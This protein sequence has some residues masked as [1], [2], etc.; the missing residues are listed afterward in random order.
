VTLSAPP[1]FTV[2]LT[3]TDVSCFGLDNGIAAVDVVTGGVFPISYEWSN[4]QVNSQINNLSSGIYDL[5]ITDDNLCEVIASIEI[6]EP[7]EILVN[8]ST[9]DADCSGNTGSASAIA[10]GGV[11]VLSYS[12][13]C[14]SAT[15]P[16]VSGIAPGSH[17]LTVTDSNSCESVES[18]DISLSG[19]ISVV[20]DI[21]QPILCYGESNGILD[22]TTSS[23][24]TPFQ[25]QWSTGSNAFS[26]SGLGAGSYTLTLTDS[27]GCAGTSTTNIIEPE[28]IALNANIT[29][30]G[31]NGDS[32]GA[33]HLSVSG[34]TSPYSY[35]WQDGSDLP[36]IENLTAGDYSITIT[37]FNSCVI[38]EIFK[39]TQSDYSFDVNAQVVHIVC[40]GDHNGEIHLSSI[41]GI[42]PIVYNVSGLTYNSTGADHT[43]LNSGTY[44]VGATDSN[45]CSDYA[46]VILS[47]PAQLAANAIVNHPSCYGNNDGSI[48]IVATGGT[49]PYYYYVDG[50]PMIADTLNAFGAGS[51]EVS[52]IDENGC[53]V[54]LGF[55]N[56]IDDPLVDCIVIP[57]A[58]TPNGDGI[59]DTW[60]IQ[61]LDVYDDV[62]IQ[63][64]NRWGQELCQSREIDFEWD[65]MFN[66]RKLPAG[67]YLYIVNVFKR[68]PYVGIVTI[69]Y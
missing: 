62:H 13:S 2:S 19:N 43:G 27:W 33:I 53:E 58:F 49:S 8:I 10:S 55:V 9:T 38:S 54:N 69:V 23:V 56:L 6:F 32:S 60:I 25:Y 57:N 67:P 64:F 29:N 28:Q 26:I 46:E 61:N 40:Y 68:K 51:Y 30:I 44:N 41:G 18:F 24:N 66:G 1:S 47:E 22:A 34:G 3:S 52:I 65:G 50:F 11:G 17:F 16:D 14:V 63:L 48:F 37:D 21:V 4:G 59:N 7:G 20:I 39:V 42:P 35:L 36:Y 31:C 5:T 12:W 45:G 15:T